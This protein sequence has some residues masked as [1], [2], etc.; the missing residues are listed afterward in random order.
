MDL[1]LWMHR[2]RMRTDT[3]IFSLIR[4]F[5]E[6][7]PEVLAVLLNG[8]RAN[9]NAKQDLL[10]DFDLSIITPHVIRFVDC[11]V[12]LDGFGDVALMQQPTL[13][14]GLWA[15]DQSKYTYLV[16]FADGNRVDF[17]FMTPDRY[18]NEADGLCQ[19]L[20]DKHGQYAQVK[21]STEEGYIITKPSEKAFSNCVNEF[22]WVAPYVAKGLWRHE[23]VYARKHLETILRE[24][25]HRLLSWQ[26]SKG[27]EWRLNLGSGY[28]LLDQY[29]TPAH[30]AM[31]CDTYGVSTESEL[32][33]SLF[34]ML[35]AFDH[36]ATEFADCEFVYKRQQY[37][38]ALDYCRFLHADKISK[39]VRAYAPAHTE[40][41][42]SINNFEQYTGCIILTADKKLLL[43]RRD[44]SFSHM[45]N[46]YSSFGGQVEEGETV[47][48]T[49]CREL[50]E[51]LGAAVNE[52]D[53]IY[54]GPVSEQATQH[55]DLIHQFFWYDRGNT[56]TGCYEGQA[57][58]FETAEQILC[59]ENLTEDVAWSVK[60]ALK[61]GLLS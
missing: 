41:L 39:K 2:C 7:E 36:I 13:M 37:T 48:Q 10:Q 40:Y 28:R 8:S 55:Q 4:M 31:V 11:V 22:Y 24:E 46:C 18:N 25:L 59:L 12:W 21:P 43:Q 52:D 9:P 51:E 17:N 33:H 14:D 3:E 42:L 29:L 6:A 1:I 61:K 20:V 30:H 32:W 38:A 23:L 47:W 35:D 54:L 15:E 50:N 58:S 53:L 27:C 19:V 49:I 5:S 44:A 60:L 45:P 26:I 16:Q 57:A 34:A 56:I